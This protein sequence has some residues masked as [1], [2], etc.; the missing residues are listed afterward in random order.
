MIG[1]Y[2]LPLGKFKMELN[3]NFN[4]RNS[5]LLSET[6]INKKVLRTSSTFRQI[7]NR[8]LHWLAK[9]WIWKIL[10]TK[11]E[12]KQKTCPP[13]NLSTSQPYGSM[14]LLFI[15]T[16][17]CLIPKLAICTRRMYQCLGIINLNNKS[18]QTPHQNLST[19][20]IT[21]IILGFSPFRIWIV[22]LIYSC[23]TVCFSSF[24][25]NVD[26]QTKYI[27]DDMVFDVMFVVG[28]REIKVYSYLVHFNVWQWKVGIIL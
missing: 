8:F 13:C 1:H 12:N 24:Q 16:N 15:S 2:T 27:C 14:F 21:L 17:H 4:K 7:F 9:N 18:I 11:L 3:V 26:V 20:S 19:L 28:C 10:I 25:T 6:Y 22:E 23:N 5:K